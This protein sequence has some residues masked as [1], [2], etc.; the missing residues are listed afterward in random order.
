VNELDR[1]WKAAADLRRGRV[2]RGR[3]QSLNFAA[4]RQ[5]GSGA[6]AA[7]LPADERAVFTQLWAGVAEFLNKAEEKFQSVGNDW[8]GGPSQA[9]G[10]HNAG[11]ILRASNPCPENQQ[12]RARSKMAVLT[13]GVRRCQSAT[14]SRSAASVQTYCNHWHPWSA[15][16][17]F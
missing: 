2:E 12:R 11:R 8:L 7:K 15:Q 3:N 17:S 6:D 9:P 16:V 4:G 1:G 5:A 10:S 13:E 14:S